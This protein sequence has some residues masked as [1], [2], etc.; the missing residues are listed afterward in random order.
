M[1][2]ADKM[3]ARA[4][5][6]LSLVAALCEGFD[7]DKFRSCADSPFCAD[8]SPGVATAPAPSPFA[9]RHST[10]RQSGTRGLQLELWQ[11]SVGENTT[12]VMRLEAV[13]SL[14]HT[15]PVWRLRMTRASNSFG[16]AEQLDLPSLS[17]FMPCELM[18][19]ASAGGEDP[20]LVV[21][22][23]T[24]QWTAE[25]RVHESPFRVAF[26]SFSNET[27]KMET[28]KME[29]AEDPK[30]ETAPQHAQTTAPSAAT[31]SVVI[32]SEALLRFASAERTLGRCH[33][34]YT[35]DDR[36]PHG[37]TAVA[38]DVSFPH[39][40]EA[41]G[42]P[43]RAAPLALA[44]TCRRLPPAEGGDAATFKKLREPYRL[45]NLDV[46]KYD[47]R[48]PIGLYGSM[49]YLLA[50][51]GVGGGGGGGGVGVGGGVGDQLGRLLLL[52][53]LFDQKI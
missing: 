31:P 11:P 44:P 18:R 32:G 49:P 36:R 4:L 50:H 10:V 47:A 12:V 14:A 39:A 40:L 17:A 13:A 46:F 2:R 48:T 7:A 34:R 45:F 29:T 33:R 3:S 20:T 26:V 25:A 27:P 43:E 35:Q 6:A 41:F 42:L 23:T 1:L 9:I 21:R 22:A 38:L 19:I 30:M 16:I 51:G 24:G 28:P 52:L 53:I 37:C 5:G 8:F 15:P